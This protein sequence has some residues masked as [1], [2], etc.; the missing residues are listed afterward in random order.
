MGRVP[1]DLLYGEL[2]LGSR[3]VGQLVWRPKI[4]FRDAYKRDIIS[5][6]LQ[7]NLLLQI[8]ANGRPCAAW[9]FARESKPAECQSRL[10]KKWRERLLQRQQHQAKSVESV[11][12]S[13]RSNI[14]LDSHHGKYSQLTHWVMDQYRR[15][16]IREVTGSNQVPRSVNT[17]VIVLILFLWIV[18]LTLSQFWL[19]PMI[20]I[21]QNAA[22]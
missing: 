22:F 21:W 14:E 10:N 8:E 7:P 13:Y 18:F 3:P 9:H 2:E 17:E 15:L 19:F 16:P 4:H 20:A 1:K 5:I 12:V 6:G 11:A